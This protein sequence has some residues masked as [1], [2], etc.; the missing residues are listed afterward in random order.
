MSQIPF[1]NSLLYFIS[2]RIGNNISNI[3]IT[4]Y[5]IFTIKSYY[6][7][8]HSTKQQYISNT[9]QYFISIIVWGKSPAFI[10]WYIK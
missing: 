6:V 1:N 7:Y 4:L 8:K 3:T 9:V 5:F 10:L 2:K